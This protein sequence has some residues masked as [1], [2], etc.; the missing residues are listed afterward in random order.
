MIGLCGGHR[1]GKTSLARAYAEK[2][3]ATFVPT[4]VSAI[5][6]ELGL[7]PAAKMDFGQ[8][9]TV[10]EEVLKRLDAIYGSLDPRREYIVD[11]TPID[12]IGYTMGD[13][14]GNAVAAEDQERFGVY[15]QRCFD[16]V[17]KRFSALILVQPGIP[18][19]EEPGKAAVNAAYIEHL[20]SLMLGL[21]VDE[22][23]KVPHYYIQRRITDLDERVKAVKRVVG[24]VHLHVQQDLHSHLEEGGVL[25]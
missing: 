3:G 12:F 2:T 13:A 5:F 9:L 6:A 14:I 21:S 19:V 1:V 18:L 8:R 20:N 4:S 11:R 10:Q 15:V 25:Q 16:V 24:K 17:N 22:R 23:V 7:D